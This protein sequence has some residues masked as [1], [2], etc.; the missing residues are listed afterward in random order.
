M[1]QG[2]EHLKLSDE[3]IHVPDLVPNAIFLLI[4]VFKIFRESALA[5]LVI[6]LLPPTWESP[7]SKLRTGA[8]PGVSDI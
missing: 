2:N 1:Y 3:D 6:G 5:A 8:A 4:T 7:T